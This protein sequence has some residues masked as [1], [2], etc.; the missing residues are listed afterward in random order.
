M[1]VLFAGGP[2]KRQQR[3]G[4]LMHNR[5]F[6]IT[7]EGDSTLSDALKIAFGK[8][9][10]ATAWRTD[11]SEGQSR[12]VLSS[13]QSGSDGW[14]PFVTALDA[15]RAVTVVKDWLHNAEYGEEPDHDGSNGR[16]WRVYCEQWGHVAPYGSPAFVAIEP[17]WAEYGK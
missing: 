1:P 5:I 4:P 2:E 7:A 10:A 16:G 9:H 12:L 8:H 3:T 14:T 17:R 6:D 11:T 15:E 13:C